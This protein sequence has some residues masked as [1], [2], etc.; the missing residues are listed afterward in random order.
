MF[1]QRQLAKRYL[2][3]FNW[4][5][6]MMILVHPLAVNATPNLG[7]EQVVRDFYDALKKRQCQKTVKLRPS[8]KIESCWKIVDVENVKIRGVAFNEKKAYVDL[9]VKYQKVNLPHPETFIG[10]I[11]LERKGDQ[12]VITTYRSSQGTRLL[13]DSVM[14]SDRKPEKPSPSMVQL[15]SA[16]L[17]I[18]QYSIIKSIRYKIKTILESIG[19]Y[20]FVDNRM[21]PGPVSEPVQPGT[22]VQP[23]P[24]H[25]E[26][27]TES[28]LTQIP[29]TFGSER[30]LR[31][32]W[33]KEE[34]NGSLQDKIIIKPL[35]NPYRDPPVRQIP[36]HKPPPLTTAWHN[37]IRYVELDHDKKLVALTFDLCE[38]TLEKTGYDSEIV[39]YLRGNKIKAT[40]FAGGKWMHSHPEKTMQL[41]AD[42]L[43]EIGNH[44]WTHGNLRVL[45]G[46]EM[47]QQII[48]TQAQYE[49]L[50]ETLNN[51]RCVLEAGS[52]EMNLIPRVPTIFR[53]PYGACDTESMGAINRFGLAAVQWN[54]VTGDP[55][56]G[57]TAHGI[58]NTILNQI[59]P[60]SIIIA[61]ANG[62]GWKT[63]DALPL[64]IPR[65]RQLGYQFVTV[66]E[67]LALGTPKIANTCY[68]HKPGDN[69]HYD[70]L[71][72]NGTG[73]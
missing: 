56:R 59:K 20:R 30:I 43:F 13:E 35:S 40:F 41:M 49:L 73:L 17:P 19:H 36:H 3:Y 15:G 18:S 61:H 48:W 14:P 26:L 10:T 44:T 50:W 47:E 70:R 55:A 53:F 25:P 24:V 2:G 11:T 37:S 6:L 60:G 28:A 31:S 67:L 69:E 8:Y 64:F 1:I 33:N 54:T 42:P 22:A 68:E 38:Q 23:K 72:G 12:W 71:F 16:R 32:C 57:Q 29:S 5:A 46:Q 52:Q 65:L 62:R 21:Q 51:Q 4:L 45:H 39:N 27:S 9:E 58:A 34:L 7:P 66:S 63:A